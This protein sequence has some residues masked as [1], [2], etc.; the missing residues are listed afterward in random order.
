APARAGQARP[1]HSMTRT[2]RES[3]L[4]REHTAIAAYFATRTCSVSCDGQR[5]PYRVA[6][7]EWLVPLPFLPA[8]ILGAIQPG[9][10]ELGLRSLGLITSCPSTTA[11]IWSVFLVPSLSPFCTQR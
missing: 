10:F 11:S 1:T 6:V 5:L 3:M 4:R 7:Q 9:G 2:R 8:R